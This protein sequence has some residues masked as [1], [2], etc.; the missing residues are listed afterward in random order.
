MQVPGD[1]RVKALE[2]AVGWL[3]GRVAELEGR[4]R[5]LEP[6]GGGEGADGGMVWEIS[7]DEESW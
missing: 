4:V 1:S 7:S 5:E 6:R 2:E 3:R